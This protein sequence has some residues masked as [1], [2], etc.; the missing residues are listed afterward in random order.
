M[1]A[2]F[3]A[4]TAFRAIRKEDPEAEDARQVRPLVAAS[5]LFL[6]GERLDPETYHWASELLGVPVIDHWWQTETGW[7]IVANPRG[8]EPLPIKP[9]SPTVP[10]PGWRRARSSTRD[11]NRSRPATRRRDRR[12]SCR[13]RRARLPTLWNDDERFVAV[14]PVRVPRLLP[15]RRRRLHRRGRLRVRDGPHRRRDQRGRPPALHRRAW[16]RSLAAH[17]AVAECAVIGV[18]DPL[19]GQVPRGFVVL[20]AGVDSDPRDAAGRTRGRWCATRSARW[21]RSATSPSC[22]P[23]RRPGRARSCARPCA[24]RRRRAVPVPSTIE[25]P[26]VLDA[27]RAQ[28]GG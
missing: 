11:G 9:G 19:K 26:A 25:D 15:H 18:A 13:C 17:P 1:K 2:L 7:P 21:P 12:S 27:L 8:L 3:T 23:C 6:A 10:C 4:P 5:T 20:K 14:V 22:R 24:D 16:R 28:L